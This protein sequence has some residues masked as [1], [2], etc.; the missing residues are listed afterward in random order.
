MEPWEL[1]QSLCPDPA[2]KI[3]T[4]SHITI[5]HLSSSW[6]A[7]LSHLLQDRKVYD[8]CCTGRIKQDVKAQSALLVARGSPFSLQNLTG[9]LQTVE[10]KI[11]HTY[12]TVKWN[13][14]PV[15]VWLK[16]EPS[17]SNNKN[18]SLL[19]NSSQIA[20]YLDSVCCKSWL[21]YCHNAY[22]HWYEQYGLDKET[23]EQ[24]YEGVQTVINSY[25]HM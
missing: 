14:F 25:K 19:V 22:W 9:N 11:S 16:S 18:M 4:P 13:P 24:A 10:K 21:K 1:S 23:F 15:D 5:T 12:N 8:V 20:S 7:V 17:S 3:I 2:L 6:E